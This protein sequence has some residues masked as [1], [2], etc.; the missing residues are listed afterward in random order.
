MSVKNLCDK[1]AQFTINETSNVTCKP[2]PRGGSCFDTIVKARPN[3]WG[4]K[5]N[6][7]IKF[8]QCPM[9]YCCNLKDCVSYDSCH[10]NRTG[11]LCGRCASK[12]SDGLF[13]SSC[14][15]NTKCS[16]SLFIPSALAK[17]VLYL[18]FFL[19]REEIETVIVKYVFSS[20]K[21]FITRRTPARN[22]TN[23]RNRC[24]GLLKVVFYY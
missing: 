7:S 15:S 21:I 13:S 2:C 12:M 5:A 16:V 17:L 1:R 24:G 19:Y 11:T 8:A 18:I 9:E 23:V 14:I 4:Y 20:L 6:T 10:G 22:P 3:F